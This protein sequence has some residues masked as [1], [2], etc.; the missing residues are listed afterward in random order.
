MNNGSLE[1]N[2]CI[3]SW[4]ANQSKTGVGERKWG[5]HMKRGRQEEEEEEGNLTRKLILIIEI[6]S[7]THCCLL[8]FFFP[9]PFV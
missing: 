1:A 7:T 5:N 9:P 6:K 3:F 8:G 2:A 4:T